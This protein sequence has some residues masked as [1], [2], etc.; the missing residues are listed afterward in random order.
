MDNELI[1]TTEGVKSQYDAIDANTVTGFDPVT[2]LSECSVARGT[3]GDKAYYTHD[4]K[5]TWEMITSD[6]D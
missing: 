4:N 1:S 6:A 5:Q 2:G 3:H